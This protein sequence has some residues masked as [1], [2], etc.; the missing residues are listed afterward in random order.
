MD[1]NLLDAR[2]NNMSVY[3]LKFSVTSTYQNKQKI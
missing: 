2:G 3:F 1:F